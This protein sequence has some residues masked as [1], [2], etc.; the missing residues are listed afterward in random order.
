MQYIDT[1]DMYIGHGLTEVR[2]CAVRRMSTKTVYDSTRHQSTVVGHL[3]ST[4]VTDS[5]QSLRRVLLYRNTVTHQPYHAVYCR[6]TR[7]Q[8]CFRLFNS[9]GA[10]TF[11]YHIHLRMEPPPQEKKI[12]TAN[13]Q[14]ELSYRKQIARKLCTQY[15]EDS[16]PVTLKSRL[17][18][19]QDH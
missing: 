17:R 3:S 2:L 14:Q 5:L 11:I 6:L 12:L 7:H 19:T 8:H 13:I 15:A 18:V 1:T 10:L 4:T 9:E 16:N